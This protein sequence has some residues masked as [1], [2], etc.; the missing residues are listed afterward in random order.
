MEF[1]KKIMKNNLK[2]KIGVGLYTCP[3]CKRD[4][5]TKQ[6]F[7]YYKDGER[8]NVCRQCRLEGC[9]DTKPWTFFNLMMLYNI[10]YIEEQWFNLLRGQ[11]F[12]TIDKGQKKGQVTYNSIF[13]KYLSMMKLKSW[14]FLTFK[15][16]PLWNK[17]RRKAYE[18]EEDNYTLYEKKFFLSNE[19][20]KNY[21]RIIGAI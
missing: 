2:D 15:D 18:E 9:V 10:P 5:L 3:Y 7:F 4:N 8:D 13:G 19:I 20:P 21:L 17:N 6:K 16:S 12:H 11:I 14:N 1:S